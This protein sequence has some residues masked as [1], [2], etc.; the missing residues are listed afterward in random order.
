MDSSSFNTA[1]SCINPSLNLDNSFS[2]SSS[3]GTKAFSFKEKFVK[4]NSYPF[5]DS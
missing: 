2:Y 4:F 1:E 3:L 5:T